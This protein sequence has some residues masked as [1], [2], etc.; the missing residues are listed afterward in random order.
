[1]SDDLTS[2]PACQGA[3]SR[4]SGMVE[5]RER[6]LQHAEYH[7]CWPEHA[8]GHGKSHLFEALVV[9]NLPAV[10]MHQIFVIDDE[11]YHKAR[12][13]FGARRNYRNS[14][15]ASLRLRSRSQYSLSS[16]PCTGYRSVDSPLA[17]VR[18]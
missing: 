11:L 14:I 13:G 17:T 12:A 18:S 5:D 6:D 1:M 16:K 7:G 10:F 9:P 8:F 2:C 15:R 4:R 3:R